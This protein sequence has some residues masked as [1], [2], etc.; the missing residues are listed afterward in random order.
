M[1]IRFAI[2]SVSALIV[3]TAIAWPPVLAQEANDL[4]SQ[5]LD[6][7]GEDDLLDD[8]LLDGVAP[9]SSATGE[10]DEIDQQL[11][12]DLDTDLGDPLEGVPLDDPDGSDVE[13]AP[14]DENLLGKIG[15]R[16]RLVEQRLKQQ[17]FA[18]ETATMQQAI[19]ND[20][21]ALLEQ[22]RQQR[23]RQQ[24]SQSSSS[25]PPSERSQPSNSDQQ[26][27]AA[28]D[29]SGKASNQPAA[30]STPGVR[31]ADASQVDV[32]ELDD[33]IKE[34]WG[35]L[36]ETAR[37]Q[38][39]QSKVERFHPKYELLIEKIYRRMAEQQDRLR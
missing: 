9:E 19:V 38:M 27:S 5:L 36:P 3:A 13:L 37:E 4:E 31:E 2:R 25:Q 24:K 39:R 20:L 15:A 22:L 7:L 1:M 10:V 18:G 11:L 16:M 29:P 33:L 32:A 35:H 14:G 17:E 8:S 12:D 34:A 30:E 28:G 26:I 21:D 6:D 23:Q